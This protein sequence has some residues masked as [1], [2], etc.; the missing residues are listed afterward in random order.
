MNTVKIAYSVPMISSSRW[1]TGIS[2]Q[3]SQPSRALH[4]GVITTKMHFGRI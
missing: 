2:K 3:Q 1:K 4:S